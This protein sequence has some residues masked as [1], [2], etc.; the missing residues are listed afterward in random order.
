[1]DA[2]QAGHEIIKTAEVR[3]QIRNIWGSPVFQDNGEVDRKR[4]GKIVFDPEKGRE[5]LARLESITHPGIRRL[6]ENQIRK[7][8]ES[9]EFPA[10]ILDA[11]VMFEAGWDEICDRIVF[12]ESSF[13]NRLHRAVQRGWSREELENREAFQI[14]LPEKRRRA[15]RIINND[16]SLEELMDQV[17]QIWSDWVGSVSSPTSDRLTRQ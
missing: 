17:K 9:G 15:N 4:L 14:P 10:A 3:D 16:G 12:V 13:Q 7:L 8:K 11:P 2:D 1:M 6:L 5:D